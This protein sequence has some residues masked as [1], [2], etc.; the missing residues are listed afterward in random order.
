MLA[1]TLFQHFYLLMNPTVPWSGWCISPCCPLCTWWPHRASGTECLPVWARAGD[2]PRWTDVRLSQEKTVSLMLNE[3]TLRLNRLFLS[4]VLEKRLSIS[5]GLRLRRSW[6][7]RLLPRFCASEARATGSIT[8]PELD[9]TL[10][11]ETKWG[12]LFFMLSS[13]HLAF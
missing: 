5:S 7:K 1:W 13:P 10:A 4:P 2:E 6:E 3:P 12:F 9:I 11:A 8:S